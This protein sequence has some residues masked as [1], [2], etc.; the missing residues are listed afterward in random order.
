MPRRVV[1]KSV[2]AISDDIGMTLSPV[3]AL[4]PHIDF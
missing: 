1:F 2:C 3:R 4:E